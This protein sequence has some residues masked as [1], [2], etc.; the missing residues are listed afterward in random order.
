M[1]EIIFRVQKNPGA[2]AGLVDAIRK[3]EANF[4]GELEGTLT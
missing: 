4:D 1:I 3:Y 2:S